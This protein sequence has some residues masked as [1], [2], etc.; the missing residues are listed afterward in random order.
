MTR[1]IDTPA[2]I[3]DHLLDRAVV[4]QTIKVLRAC[5]RDIR[6][7]ISNTPGIG[8]YAREL[9]TWAYMN[10]PRRHHA[11]DKRRGWAADYQ[12]SIEYLR[13]MRD[14]AFLAQP[15]PT[16]FEIRVANRKSITGSLH[17]GL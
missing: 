13:R 9:A 16:R 8:V 2:Y 4:R 1:A 3:F 5:Q 14:S 6:Y 11:T 12:R 7:T 15:A 10:H 17:H